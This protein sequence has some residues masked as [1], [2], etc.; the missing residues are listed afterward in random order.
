MSFSIRRNKATLAVTT[1]VGGVSSSTAFTVTGLPAYLTPNFVQVHPTFVANGA[2]TPANRPAI[3]SISTG[4]VMTF[5]MGDP[6]STTGFT[7][8]G[9]PKGL[10][11]GWMLTYPLWLTLP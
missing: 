10:T 2:V 11:V 7:N 9:N 1:L 4:G 3:V 5:S 8:D 6:F